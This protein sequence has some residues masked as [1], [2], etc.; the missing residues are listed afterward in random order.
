MIA[1]LDGDNGDHDRL[2]AKFTGTIESLVDCYESDP[3]SGYAAVQ[4][5]TAAGYKPWLKLLRETVGKRLI[6]RIVA[7]ETR[8]WYREWKALAA[9]RGTDG[10]RT[11][12]GCIQTLKTLLNYG[13][14]C[15]NESCRLCVPKTQTRT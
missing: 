4:E 11:A 3:D 1:W 9:R 7:K 15:G 10:V 14:E 2:A 6:A 8:R 5:N 12:Y 13:I